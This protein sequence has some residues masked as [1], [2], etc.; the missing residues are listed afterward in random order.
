MGV[1]LE[2]KSGA[3]AGQTVGLKT[4]E[5][6]TVGRP[7]GQAEFVI[8]NDTSMSRLHFVVE[9]GTQ[10]CRVTDRKS[11]N[12]TFL[13]GR[14]L[15]EQEPTLLANGD[16]I[17]AG[18]TVFHVKIVADEK[19]A[20]MAPP[21]EASPARAQ[22]PAPKAA[23][24]PSPSLPSEPAPRPVAPP[25]SDPSSPAPPARP[26]APQLSAPA[27]HAVDQGRE[28]GSAGPPAPLR[29]PPG[30]FPASTPPAAAIPRPAVPPAAR[31][32]GKSLAPAFSVMGWS[33]FATPDQW[34]VQEG[35]G[36]QRMGNGEF[37]SSVAATEEPLG[38]FTLPQYVESQISVLRGYLRDPKI[39]PAMPPE[40]G[41]ADET[42]AV[43]VRH[44]TKDGKEL[45]YRRIY[46]R[47]GASVGVL[48][49][50]ALAA[51]LPQ[52]L[53]SL[54]S[55]LDSATFRAKGSI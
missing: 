35:F 14:K 28:A 38:E 55:L 7:G 48:T 19:L 5:R 49:V 36:L 30:S 11:A 20:S 44:T 27:A 8:G 31:L 51:E 21:H 43:D 1:I 32:A 18:Q 15:R 2:I 10:G 4:G 47:S 54:Q 34:Q 50:T 25:E 39:E 6:V 13:N 46:A 37:P 3:M 52:V 40:V 29:P 24:L 53:K 16:E 17:K 12:G 23:E 42:M 22:P 41:G 26:P 33:F 9:C 45:I